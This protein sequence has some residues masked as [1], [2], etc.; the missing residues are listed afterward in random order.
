MDTSVLLHPTSSFFPP[1]TLLLRGTCATSCRLLI[2]GCAPRALSPP[3]MRWLLVCP[4]EVMVRC[5]RNCVGNMYCSGFLAG[6]D[7]KRG[8]GKKGCLATCDVEGE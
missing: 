1:L 3:L 4:T 6:G 2:S 8:D 5:D 7:V